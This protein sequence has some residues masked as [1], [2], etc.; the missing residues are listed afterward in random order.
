MIEEENGIKKV[1]FKVAGRYEPLVKGYA[2]HLAY[3]PER[4]DFQSNSDGGPEYLYD[5]EPGVYWLSSRPIFADKKIDKE[6]N[7]A[8]REV[9]IDRGEPFFRLSRLWW[10]A[11]A[12]LAIGA[13]LVLRQEKV[14]FYLARFKQ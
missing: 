11:G 6:A 7:Y 12:V 8:Y 10:L 1:S 13:V 4:P 14:R 3:E 2:W 5:L 9:K